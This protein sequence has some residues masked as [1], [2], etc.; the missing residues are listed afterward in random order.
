MQFNPTEDDCKAHETAL[1][2]WIL[3]THGA[4]GLSAITEAHGGELGTLHQHYEVDTGTHDN[5]DGSIDMGD[6]MVYHDLEQDKKFHFPRD[7][8]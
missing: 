8:G 2:N 5:S 4:E 1:R 6:Y 7:H 3:D